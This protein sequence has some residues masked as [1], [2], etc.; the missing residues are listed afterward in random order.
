MD[1]SHSFRLHHTL[2]ILSAL[3]ITLRT[4]LHNLRPPTKKKRLNAQEK[5]VIK[6]LS[7]QNV[8]GILQS[9]AITAI[10]S[11]ANRVRSTYSSQLSLD[12]AAS[13]P[14]LTDRVVRVSFAPEGGK[15]SAAETS[16]GNPVT[17]T[18]TTRGNPVTTGNPV[19]A[20]DQVPEDRSSA[21][22]DLGSISNISVGGGSNPPAYDS[23][24][25]HSRI[26]TP[27]P[28]YSTAVQTLAN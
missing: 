26:S 16:R 14:D 21:T 13:V 6:I 25:A 15:A 1:R 17:S 20:T 4:A 18:D 10:N 2:C 9:R 7:N 11:Q 19:S 22:A 28:E 5:K 12:S 24:S 3:S 23:L 27:P 8:R